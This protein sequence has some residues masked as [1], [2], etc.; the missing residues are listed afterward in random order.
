MGQVTYK[1]KRVRRTKNIVEVLD[2]ESDTNNVLTNNPFRW[3]PKNDDFIF[4]GRSF[5]LEKIAEETGGTIKEIMNELQRRK[6]FLQLMDDKD[7]TYYKDVG[8]AIAMYYVDADNAFDELNRKV[9][10][11]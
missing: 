3:N 5:V 10:L 7:V 11:A 6:E 4:S 1:G 8:R 9:T 2:L